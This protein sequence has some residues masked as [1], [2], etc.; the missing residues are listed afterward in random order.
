MN[1]TTK[2]FAR[3][4]S[5]QDKYHA[6]DDKIPLSAWIVGLALLASVFGLIPFLY[7]VM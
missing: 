5:N 3:R 2:S 6:L 7:W 4:M 1:I